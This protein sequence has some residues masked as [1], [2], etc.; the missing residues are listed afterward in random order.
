MVLAAAIGTAA[1]A[2][3]EWFA[4]WAFARLVLEVLS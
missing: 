1:V 2:A 3:V 4:G